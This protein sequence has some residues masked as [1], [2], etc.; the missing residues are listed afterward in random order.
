MCGAFIYRITVSRVFLEKG[1]HKQAVV[2]RMLL[3]TKE[4]NCIRNTLAGAIK[5]KNTVN[6][7]V[8][9]EKH[10]PVMSPSF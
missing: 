9:Y 2:D 7:D 10:S 3:V 6:I 4:L 5:T 8:A 1:D